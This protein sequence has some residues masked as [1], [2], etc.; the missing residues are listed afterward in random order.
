[1][2]LNINDQGET[3]NNDYTITATTVLRSGAAAINYFNLENLVVNPGSAPIIF[4]A[5]P[6]DLPPG[7]HFF[8]KSTSAVTTLNAQLF[9]T[10]IVGSDT[11]SLDGIQGALNVVG[12]DA[13]ILNDQGDNNGNSYTITRT[14]VARSGAAL[15]S[16]TNLD[17]NS[18]LTINAGAFNDTLNVQ[19]AL[20]ADLNLGAGND[21]VT[22]V[23]TDGVTPEFLGV[24]VHGGAGADAV[25]LNDPRA[26]PILAAS[27][28]DVF[29]TVIEQHT[30]QGD[31]F[32]VG[33]DAVESVTIN[34][35]GG[36][37]TFI[38]HST[39]ATTPVTL[40]G[41]GGN[42]SFQFAL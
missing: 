4:I 24:G 29:S 1:D 30:L 25:V 14:S 26:I 36:D 34:A 35:A 11:N 41:G 2:Q 13:L 5:S 12:G 18:G 33:Y 6:A 9:D 32:F 31:A 3:E 42:D 10:I 21:T 27:T 20:K 19:E 37:D 17:F 7:N 8:V 22:L 39:L 16:F 28:Y 23:G 40:H 15:I 38:L